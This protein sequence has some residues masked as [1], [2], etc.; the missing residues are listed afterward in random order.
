MA[1][2]EIDAEV[3]HQAAA[4]D[5]K[6]RM[7]RSAAAAS[8]KRLTTDFLTGRLPASATAG[9]VS[10]GHTARCRRESSEGIATTRRLTPGDRPHSIGTT[11]PCSRRCARRPQR[12]EKAASQC[13]QA[14]VRGDGAWAR[15]APSSG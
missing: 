13:E 7:M 5:V 3:V 14:K 9:G 10:S 4:G 1:L 2:A 11:T 12:F 6:I 8:A 15:S